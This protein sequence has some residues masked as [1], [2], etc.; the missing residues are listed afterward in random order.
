MTVVALPLKEDSVV[1]LRRPTVG[2]DLVMEGVVR[3]YNWMEP[4]LR[5]DRMSAHLLRTMCALRSALDSVC[6]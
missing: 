1:D 6:F 3:G 4:L 5:T 2:G